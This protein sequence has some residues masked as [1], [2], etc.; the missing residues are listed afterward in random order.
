MKDK[1]ENNSNIKENIMTIAV[2]DVISIPPSKS[3]KEAA[4]MMMKHDF[5]RLPVTD[6]GSGKLL[7]IITVMDIIDFLGGGSKYNIISKKYDDNFLAA[8]NEPV[9]EIMTRDVITISDKGSIEKAMNIMLQMSVGS[10]PIVDSDKQLVG[11]IT[12]RDIA[13]SFADNLTEQTANE[14]MA[15]NIV[16]TTP[17]TPIESACKM[18]VR[19]HFRRIPIVGASEY[20]GSV[21]KL[22]GIVTTTN[23]IKFFNDQKLFT[24]MD[25]NAASDVLD[26]KISEIMASDVII[27]EP[28]EKLG[29][30][31]KIFKDNNIGGLPVVEN[32][33][34]IGII[35]E[36]DIL[37]A[38][39]Q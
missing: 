29:S 16:S 26:N 23:I 2:K 10:L 33:K 9:R 13:L 7:G 8:I 12:E 21:K 18:M 11:I 20:D 22:L 39:N 17:G 1:A 27:V 28:D 19:N 36:K 32:D 30:V 4:E 3:I 6:A 15:T 31:C 25:S 5:R 35:T 14:F 38:F 37:R 24:Q 34:V